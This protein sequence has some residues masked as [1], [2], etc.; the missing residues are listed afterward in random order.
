MPT[1]QFID[2]TFKD[3][4]K[5]TKRSGGVLTGQSL[6][7]W[8]EHLGG[9][10]EE[11]EKEEALEFKNWEKNYSW[12]MDHMESRSHTNDEYWFAYQDHKLQEQLKVTAALQ[13]H[14]E[15]LKAKKDAEK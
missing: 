9:K 1:N 8:H 13:T 2:T 10:M 3:W 4:C 5:E 6:K 14:D 7:E 12:I 11:R 15:L